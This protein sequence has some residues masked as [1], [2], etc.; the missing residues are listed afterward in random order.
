MSHPSGGRSTLVTN[1]RL[2]DG[3][4]LTRQTS[5]LITGATITAI[6]LDEHPADTLQING[7][8]GVLL[9][10]LID[11]HV[12]LH[13]L[14]NLEQFTR[15]GVTTALD[16]ASWPPEFVDELRDREGLTDIRS[17]GIPASSPGSRHSMMPSYPPEGLLEGPE[18]AEQFVAQRVAEGADYIKL[19]AD[20][21][22]PSQ[23]LLDR[24][25]IA[26]RE[27]GKL[28]VVHAASYV[29]WEM[30]INCG[31]DVI[32]HA[33]L[34][35]EL[36]EPL[37]QEMLRHR[38][39]CV[40]TLSMMEAI[41]DKLASVVPDAVGS[42]GF[43]SYPPAM[44]SVNLLHSLGVPILAGTDANASPEAPANVPHGESLHHELELLVDAGL[45]PVEALRAATSGPAQYFR[46]PDRGAIKPGFRADLLLIA[47]DPTEDV[48]ATRGI[49]EVWCAGVRYQPN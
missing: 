47:G 25:V 20:A 41:A 22:G 46:I 4:K 3:D 5:V 1:V 6:G 49:A 23:E 44:A 8:G 18:Q 39:A 27:H 43:P 12:H 19:V 36:D 21:P 33:P 7:D 14:E 42:P 32:T 38:R 24:L 10:G 34:D 15:Y 13:G 11:A 16:M 9:P 45:S 40:P 31:A 2:F 35:R 29:A 28:T 48:T 17:A 37:V 26:A 30:A